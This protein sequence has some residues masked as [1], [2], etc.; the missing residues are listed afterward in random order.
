VFLGC[1]TVKGVLNMEL[2]RVYTIREVCKALSV[3]DVT[4]YRMLAD[5]RLRGVK[6]GTRWRVRAVDLQDFLKKHT[7][8]NKAV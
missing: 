7:V 6:L 1:L 4:V 8:K 5:G 3:T 2:E